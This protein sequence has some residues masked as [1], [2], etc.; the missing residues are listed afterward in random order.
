[1]R[2]GKT[3]KDPESQNLHGMLG[4]IHIILDDELSLIYSER[5]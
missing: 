3:F 4:I 5:N 2:Q 1:M